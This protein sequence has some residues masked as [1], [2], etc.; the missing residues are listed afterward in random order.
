MKITAAGSSLLLLTGAAFAQLIKN[1]SA[2][3]SKLITDKKI[4]LP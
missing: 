4:A 1:E 3:W 2:M